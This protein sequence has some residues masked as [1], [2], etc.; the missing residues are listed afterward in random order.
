MGW[1]ETDMLA[2]LLSAIRSEQDVRYV[3]DKLLR[4]NELNA[5]ETPPAAEKYER[6][7]ASRN[8]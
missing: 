4:E 8:A 7:A 2:K 3:A 5:V 6:S 1:K